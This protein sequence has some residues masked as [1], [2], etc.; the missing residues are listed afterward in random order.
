M[1][2][3]G[4]G[5]SNM[6]PSG[7]ENPVGWGSNWKKPSMVGY[8][9]FLEPHIVKDAWWNFHPNIFNSSTSISLF[10]GK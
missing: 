3:P 8:K 5:G 2:I 6:K 7:T 10:S 9:Y 1:E 4:G